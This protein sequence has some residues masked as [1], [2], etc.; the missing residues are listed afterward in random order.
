MPSTALML[1]NNLSRNVAA[2]RE[3]AKNRRRPPKGEEGTYGLSPGLSLTEQPESALLY[4]R[5]VQNQP[6]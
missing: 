1:T 5:T 4:Q 2:P 6:D 3:D